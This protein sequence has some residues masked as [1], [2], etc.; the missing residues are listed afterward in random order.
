MHPGHLAF[1]DVDRR[2]QLERSLA[3]ARTVLALL[4]LVVVLNELPVSGQITPLTGNLIIAYN[5]Y[6]LAAA[7]IIGLIRPKP[8]LGAILHVGDILWAVTINTAI[9]SLGSMASVFYLFAF[10]SAGYRWGLLETLLTGLTTAGL[11][12]LPAMTSLPDLMPPAAPLPTHRV[13]TRALSIVGLAGVIGYLADEQNR[14]RAHAAATTRVLAAVDL[15]GGLRASLQRVLAILLTTFRATQVVMLFEEGATGRVYRWS[16]TDADAPAN[17]DELPSSDHDGWLFPVSGSVRAWRLK[18]RG[19]SV[20]GV[21]D[22]VVR[23]RRARRAMPAAARLPFRQRALVA[24]LRIGGEWTGRLLDL[25]SAVPARH[26]H[27]GLARHADGSPGSGVVQFVSASAIAFPRHG[28][29]A[30]ASCT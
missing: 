21:S 30:H 28:I 6:A 25:G 13:L 7:V 16:L 24:G 10:V 9:E 15:A 2:A 19:A 12:V 5:L 17:L 14:S 26:T 3:L 18:R 22:V 8:A 11:Q 29:R 27:R 20:G 4:A 1:V 23:R